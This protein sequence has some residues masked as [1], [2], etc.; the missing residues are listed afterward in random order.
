MRGQLDSVSDWRAVVR[1]LRSTDWVRRASQGVVDDLA[2]TV[3]PID[4]RVCGGPLLR[5]EESAMC[6]GCLS[7]IERQSMTLCACCGEGFGLENSRLAG[8]FDGARCAACR[9]VPPE[10]ER[11]VAYGV[12]EDELREAVHLLKYERA[13]G[14]ATP[15]GKMLAEAVAEIA[16]R[17]M[18]VV[19]VPLFAAKQRARGYN[20]SAVLA[21]AAMAEL[22][23][24]GGWKL[25]AAH[26]SMKRVGDT[27]SQFGLKPRQRR[28]NLRGA[29]VV[30]D[31]AAVTGREV[32]LVDDILTTGATARECARVLRAAGA[33]RVWVAT[34]ARAQKLEKVAAWDGWKRNQMQ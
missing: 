21:D 15:L 9:M 32:L 28:D 27:K 12:Y 11:A 8:L 23:R 33:E 1:V 18:V 7:Q 5:A 2:A 4:C 24:R 13:R 25:T 17:E 20:Q 29:F 3:F 34:L 14:L 6:D 30:S 10:F 26:G 22:R 31:A 19:A 16:A